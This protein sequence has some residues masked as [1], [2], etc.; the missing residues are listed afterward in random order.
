M[1]FHSGLCCDVPSDLGSVVT[2]KHITVVT[3]VAFAVDMTHESMLE[4]VKFKH[5]EDIHINLRT[6]SSS[7]RLTVSTNG[8]RGRQCLR[9]GLNN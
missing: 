4:R 8:V 5:R 9:R 3:Y 1:V 2:S 7:A 6:P